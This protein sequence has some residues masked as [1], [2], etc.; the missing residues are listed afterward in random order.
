MGDD[1]GV[2]RQKGPRDQRSLWPSDVVFANVNVYEHQG[3]LHIS[4]VSLRFLELLFM[5]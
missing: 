4:L 5:L 3:L 1:S 2:L